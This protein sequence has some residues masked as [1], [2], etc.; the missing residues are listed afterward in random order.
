MPPNMISRWWW[1][2]AELPQCRDKLLPPALPTLLDKIL[3]G[4]LTHPA[5]LY[6]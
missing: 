4:W 3:A 2:H 5:T 1:S 6:H